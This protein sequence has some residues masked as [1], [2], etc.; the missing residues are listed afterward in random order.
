MPQNF[1]LAFGGSGIRCV[2]ALSY[3]CASR[4]LREPLHVLLVDPDASNGNVDIVKDQLQR[5]YHVQQHV[6]AANGDGGAFFST[7]LN[8]G[9]GAESF[10]W[11]YP[12]QNQAFGTLIDY[13]GQSGGHRQ[14]LD[15]LYDEDDLGLSFEKGYIGR[16]HIGSL[17][18]LGTLR[19]A[20]KSATADPEAE[21]APGDDPLRVFFRALRAAAQ[22][23]AGAKLLVYGSIFGGTGASGLPTVPPLIREELARVHE[24]IEIGCVQLA[25]YFSFPGGQSRDPDSTLHQ[26]STQAA[27]YHY[28]FTD[29]GYRRVYLVGAPDRLET[30]EVNRPGG[31]AQR[32]RAHYV[33]LG[34]ALA[35]A[36]FFGDPAQRGGGTQVFASGADSVAWEFLP[37]G[38]RVRARERLVAFATFCM[39]HSQY[40]YDDLR[41]GRHAGAKWARDLERQTGRRLGGR[42]T[43]LEHLKNFALRFL[44]WSRD[45]QESV[46]AGTE[47]FHVD[48]DAGVGALARVT[49]GGH[50]DRDPYHLLMAAFS[51]AGHVDETSPSGW[52]VHA[53][54]RAVDRFCA[55][56]YSSWWARQ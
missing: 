25:P 50:R 32:N 9:A 48:R 17:D 46:G 21:P 33:E 14:L 2:E 53:A 16:A 29:T 5:Y 19:R 52:Y 4:A 27:L 39:L 55:D 7:P 18:L 37:H 56:N 12:N 31:I 8:P 45:V 43:E 26:L 20:V 47:L 40:L 3:L 28:A 42:E 35:G 15:L 54:S 6:R 23:S 34:A 11:Q 44:E 24:N 22:G 38:Q 1:V 36:H 49:E 30:N 51:R 10:L 41:E 13:T